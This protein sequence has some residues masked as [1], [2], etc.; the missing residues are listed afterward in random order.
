MTFL[1]IFSTRGE[2][3]YFHMEGSTQ[4]EIEPMRG[5]IETDIGKLGKLRKKQ[6]SFS[7]GGDLW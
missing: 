6:I 4:G 2:K 1:G 7:G 3:Y 5:E